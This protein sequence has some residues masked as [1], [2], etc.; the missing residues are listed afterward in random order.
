MRIADSHGFGRAGRRTARQWM[1][2]FWVVV[3]LVLILLPLMLYMASK[4]MRAAAFTQAQIGQIYGQHQVIEHVALHGHLPRELA[5]GN[6]EDPDREADNSSLGELG[7]SFRSRQ[8][9][10][11]DLSAAFEAAGSTY[12]VRAERSGIVDGSL[13]TIGRFGLS[14]PTFAWVL[15]PAVMA[16]VPPQ[17]VAWVCDLGTVHA[18]WHSWAPPRLVLLA[19]IRSA[20]LC[21]TEQLR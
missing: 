12:M 2:E 8:L 7:R 19:E 14:G 10:V 9:K 11:Q 20:S 6:F 3:V 1:L 21:A 13:V 15:R 16:D 4:A 17:A 5:A 18:P